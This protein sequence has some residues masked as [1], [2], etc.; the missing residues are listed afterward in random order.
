MADSPGGYKECGTSE[1]PQEDENGCS[2]GGSSKVRQPW[3]DDSC[4]SEQLRGLS[5]L[6]ENLVGFPKI[7]SMK[8]KLH[9]RLWPPGV[10]HFQASVHSASGNLLKS[11]F[12][13]SYQFM[14]L[15]ASASD[16]QISVVTPWIRLSL[17]I[18]G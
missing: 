11:L 7:K 5:W 15:A 16:K 3:S 13:C 18:S 9:T 4:D 8:V 6:Y 1:D 17:Q 10:S 12:K 14:I 2:A